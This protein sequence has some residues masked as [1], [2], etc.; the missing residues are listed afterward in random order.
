MQWLTLLL[1]LLTD[2]S[3][4]VRLEAAKAMLGI[5]PQSVPANKQADLQQAMTELQ[6]SLQAKVDYP[7]GQLVM[8]GV[9]LTLRSYQAASQAF[10]R[11]VEM[12]PQ[13]VDG[14]VILIRIQAALGKTTEARNLLLQ[15]LQNNPDSYQI[16][17][18]AASMGLSYERR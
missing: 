16:E 5:P 17:Q 7:E 11:A 2:P 10:K 9:A 12:D 14:W 3:K 13:L 18:L 1:P 4:S 6:Q 15:A 8:G